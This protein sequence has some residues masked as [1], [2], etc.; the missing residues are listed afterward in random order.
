MKAGINRL[1]DQ[2]ISLAGTKWSEWALFIFAF[3]DASFLPMPA[4]TFFLILIMMNGAKSI[5]YI[6]FG[7]MGTLVGALA[8]YS[9]GHFA[10][11][12]TS[13]ELT[14]L[15]HFFLNNIPGFTP[16]SYDKMHMLYSKWDFWILFLAAFA[17]LPY[18]IFAISSGVFDISIIIFCVATVISQTIKFFVMAYL[19]RRIGPKVKFLTGLKWKPVALI[20]SI[21]VILAIAI[22]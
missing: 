18:G 4:S 12:N 15:G 11:L 8:G 14:G 7:T 22:L 9:V 5:R 17:P 16:G 20:A 3:V 21:F 10:W 13:G 6:I 2:T 1:Y 19:L